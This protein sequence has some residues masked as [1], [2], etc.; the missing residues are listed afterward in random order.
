ML[1][2]DILRIQTTTANDSE[3]SHIYD[4][5]VLKGAGEFLHIIWYCSIYQ[6]HK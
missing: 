1:M 5:Q 2:E 6:S 3:M 4:C